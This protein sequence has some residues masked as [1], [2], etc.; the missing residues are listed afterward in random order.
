MLRFCASVFP[1]MNTAVSN[2]RFKKSFSPAC[3]P[4]KLEYKPSARRDGVPLKDSPS[5][6]DIHYTKG[7][8]SNSTE[9]TQSPWIA[10]S[11]R[12]CAPLPE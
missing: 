4:S 9:V 8:G 5:D 10:D 6:P 1:E 7:S 11:G 3:M 2:Q 12:V